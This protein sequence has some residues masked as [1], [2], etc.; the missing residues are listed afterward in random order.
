MLPK[1]LLIFGR[2]EILLAF[3]WAIKP[4]G[5][6]MTCYETLFILK[7]TLTEEEITAQVAKITAILSNEGAEILAADDMGM[8]KLAYEIEKNPR[9]YYTV[10][11]Y[12]AEG[13]MLNEL[14]RNLRINEEVLRFL[15]VKYVKQT[16]L[17]QFDKLVAAAKKKGTADTGTTPE[18][19]LQSEVVGA[20]EV[21]ADIVNEAVEEIVAEATKA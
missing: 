2:V 7:P 13:T 15:T 20:E 12:K 19:E 16:E 4:K 9:G 21:A 14:E 18:A 1:F 10:L 17:T 3:I 5:N 11:L 8:R 6:N